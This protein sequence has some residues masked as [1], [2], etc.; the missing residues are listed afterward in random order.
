MQNA[1][2]TKRRKL[3]LFILFIVLAVLGIFVFTACSEEAGEQTLRNKGYQ[4][5]V[6]YDFN[7]G[8]WNTNKSV[9]VAVKKNSLLPAPLRTNGGVGFPT[10]KNYSFKGF[11]PAE[12]DE[13]GNVV[14]DENGKVVI[15]DTEWNFETD[16]VEDKDF[17]LYAKWWDNYK[18]VLHYG[19][20]YEFS[21]EIDL[22]R[23]QDGSPVTITA[24]SLRVN[25]VTFLSYN[26]VKDST[27]E[28]TALNKFPFD[29][30]PYVPSGDGLE[31]D[32]WGKSLMGNYVLVRSASDLSIS[33]VGENTNYYL[34]EDIDFKGEKY[35]ESSSLQTTKLPKSYG[36]K[37]I[38]NGHT[39]S[40]FNIKMDTLDRTYN[41]FGLFRTLE[42][43]AEITGVTFNNFTFSYDLSNSNISNYYVGMLAGQCEQNVKIEDVHFTSCKLEYLVGTGVQDGSVVI[44]DDLLVAQ[45]PQSVVLNNCSE[46]ETMRVYST[47]VLTDDQEYIIYVKYTLDNDA[48][49]LDKDSIYKLAQKNSNGNYSNKT[50]E[51]TEYKGNNT[52]VLTRLD[53]SEY[54]VTITVDNGKLH[55]TMVLKETT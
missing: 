12:T 16:R 28:A 21:T 52:Y 4:V 31:I 26:M 34:L 32:V 43:G 41:S 47:G 40:N 11:Y 14:Y 18:V 38:G 55:A 49:V 30:S 9:T 36:G 25:D 27:D 3:F 54:D 15:S 5:F 22:S 39:I 17:T 2:S 44:A 42:S 53:G 24:N 10:R 19:E 6:V 8:T 33:S 50:I 37:F 35:D 20:S 45:K 46:T 23:N 13:D 7:G 1:I 51:S 29:L 48:I